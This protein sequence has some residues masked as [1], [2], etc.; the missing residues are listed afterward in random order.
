MLPIK[1]TQKMKY[2]LILITLCIAFSS[3]RKSQTEII[4]LGTVHQPIQNFNSDSL[5]NILVK[6]EPDLIL[7]EVD[8]SFFTKDFKFNRTW[9]SNE[10]IAT[11]K[12]M[13]NFKVN[14]RPYEFT[15]RNEYRMKIGSRP[16]D[17]KA[18]KLLDSLYDNNLLDSVNAI[19]YKEYLVINDSLN[20]FAYLGARGFNNSTTDKIAHLRQQYQY[21][22]LLKIM[23]SYPIF[24]NTY[25]A[26][27][28]NDSITYAEGYKRASEFWNLRNRTMAKN[29]L[30]FAKEFKGKRIVVLNGY[31]HRYYLNSLIRPKLEELDFTVKEFYEL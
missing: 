24:S 25:Y 9:E 6:L 29:I 8:S 18:T 21:R 17:S 16:T 20:S 2:I 13:T 12:Y 31:F 19:I 11:I 14:V 23:Q 15:G 26:L 10:N 30:H 1:Q 3:C 28:E 22:D 5:Y 4:L 7:F 27:N